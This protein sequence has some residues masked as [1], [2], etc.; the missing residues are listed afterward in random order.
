MQ[1]I[2]LAI[3]FGTTNSAA[4]IRIGAGDPVVVRLADGDTMPS[5]VW[6]DGDEIT[7]G[8]AALNNA[9]LDPDAFERS[10]K[11]R[12]GDGHL[13]LGGRLWAVSDLVAAVLRTIVE[14]ARRRLPPGSDFSQV[15]LTHPE[16]WGQ[17]RVDTLRSAATGAGISTQILHLMPEPAAAACFYSGT[18]ADHAERFC[19]FDFGGG[20]CDVSV[21]ERSGDTYTILASRGD[22][23]LG[24]DDFDTRLR[25]WVFQQLARD[26][27][28]VTT[29]MSSVGA[30]LT[31]M[32]RARD[33][34]E[35]LSSHSRAVIGLPDGRALQI[36][37]SELTE[38]CGDLIDRATQLTRDVLAD[39]KGGPMPIFLSGGA[40]HLPQ[41]HER[42][43][44]L[45]EVRGLGDPKTVVVLGAN[46]SKPGESEE[47][48]VAPETVVRGQLSEEEAIRSLNRIGVAGENLD[49]HRDPTPIPAVIDNDNSI[50]REQASAT[51]GSS[52]RSGKWMAGA[53][54]AA[55]ALIVVVILGVASAMS[56]DSGTDDS[57]GSAVA[58]SSSPSD[59][60]Q[61]YYNL[62]AVGD[63]ISRADIDWC[64]NPPPPV[65]PG[66]I[67]RP[68]RATP[69]NR[70]CAMLDRVP[71]EIATNGGCLYLSQAG[72]ESAISCSMTDRYAVNVYVRDLYTAAGPSQF[73]AVVGSATFPEPESA[74]YFDAPNA[75]DYRE[76]WRLVSVLTD[77]A[78]AALCTERQTRLYDTCTTYNRGL[79]TAQ[80][81]FDW[82]RSQ[83]ELCAD[84]TPD[85]SG[86]NE[87][88]TIPLDC[89]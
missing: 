50:N 88:I 21:L 62:G 77:D 41:I 78:R 79:A 7:V 84:S 54:A 43:A 39:V 26:G 44:D 5:A 24:G 55:A 1:R 38:V 73:S 59:T 14:A 46:F 52:R 18:Q 10:P 16:S 2:A 89:T 69:Y 86:N 3:D 64:L 6:V 65:G 17:A 57:G 82:W 76:N 20:T 51:E 72:Y 12:I 31:L 8:S 37:R 15:I 81:A 45:G 58:E 33:A 11:R 36:T 53:A 80:E 70:L 83:A 60:P 49:P 30:Q 85:I 35:T 66:G 4:A 47:E 34:K 56:A 27:G 9:L 68:R 87:D 22:T 42:L 74:I 71:A 19:V 40:S 75:S 25:G 48:P 29:A 28:D 67:I 32:D 23:T 13:V 63:P 61:V